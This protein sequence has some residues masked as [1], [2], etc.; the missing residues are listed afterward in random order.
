MA[1]DVIW[2]FDT[3]SIIEIR[4]SIE[5]ARKQAVFRAMSSLV[6]SGRLVFPIQVVKEL[7]RFADPNL[8]DAQYLWAK[9]NEE[10]A[11]ARHHH[12]KKSKI[13]FHSCQTFLIRI[14]IRVRRK[15]THTSLQLHGAS[16]PRQRMVA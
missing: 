4:R 10:M 8:P 15:L 13:S 6:S 14:R 1:Q 12:S 3:S 16:G 5:N 2:V 9:A 7:E 11:K